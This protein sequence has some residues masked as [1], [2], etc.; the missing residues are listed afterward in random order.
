M[1]IVKSTRIFSY[2]FRRNG[3]KRF[4]QRMDYQALKARI[5]FVRGAIL[6]GIVSFSFYA[7]KQINSR[8][9]IMVFF[10]IINYCLL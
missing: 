8:S 9:I 4:A 3:E 5:T 6:R 7:I 1:E 10:H 2:L